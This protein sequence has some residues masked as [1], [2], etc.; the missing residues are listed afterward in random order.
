M[1][2]HYEPEHFDQVKAFARRLPNFDYVKEIIRVHTKQHRPG[3]CYAWTVRKQVVAFCAVA[4]LNPDDAWLWGMR[5]DDQFKS[6]GIATRFTRELFRIAARDGR[7]W[8]GLNTLDHR[9]PAPV[10]RVAEKLGMRLESIHATDPFWN[11][12]TRRLT[13]P[14]LKRMPDIFTHY[15]SRGEKTIFHEGPGWC[16]SRLLPDRQDWVNRNGF[17]VSGLPVHVHNQGYKGTG[18][19]R[20][21][22]VT[23]NLLDR[24]DDFRDVL[25]SVLAYAVGRG[26]GVTINYPAAWKQELRRAARELVPSLK[27]GRNCWSTVWRIYGKSLT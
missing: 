22:H 14:R 13:R 3:G 7:T 12:R 6:K 20:R 25:G 19:K 26:H 5:V 18:K 23:V 9:R 21:H 16:W 2:E 17:Q 4:Y 27:R 1:L 10:F 15:L 11:L 8:A 24:P